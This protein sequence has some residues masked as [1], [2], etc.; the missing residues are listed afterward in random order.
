MKALNINDIILPLVKFY[1]NN[2]EVNEDNV[3][4]IIK[5]IKNETNN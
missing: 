1:I 5:E 2:I 4:D 3:D